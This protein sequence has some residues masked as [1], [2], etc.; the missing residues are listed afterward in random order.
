MEA[1]ST[2]KQ[3][4]GFFPV[5]Q[6]VTTGRVADG[7]SKTLMFGE[8]PGSVGSNINVNGTNYSGLVV[9]H[10][11]AGDSTLPTIFGLFSSTETQ[12]CDAFTFS[13]LHS[14]DIVLFAFGDAGVKPLQ[15]SID[16]VVLDALGSING[17]E[18]VDDAILP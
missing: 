17:N 9:G 15:K 5:R 1:R 2:D 18:T 13:S 11:W 6:E 4:L 16:L 7:I 12:D 8:C 10:A 14:G 3:L